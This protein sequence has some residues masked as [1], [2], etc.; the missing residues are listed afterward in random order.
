MAPDQSR[1][2][3]H[4]VGLQLDEA[5]VVAKG[6]DRPMPIGGTMAIEPKV[7]H[8]EGCIGSEDTWTRDEDGLRPLTAGG[9]WPWI[10]T[11]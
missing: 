10:T 7:V 2:L 8:P 11:W 4:S 1:F 5:P 3:G 6:F 9:A